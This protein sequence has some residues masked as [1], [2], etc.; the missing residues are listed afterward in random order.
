MITEVQSL[1]FLVFFS[2][3]YCVCVEMTHN[4]NRTA[5]WKEGFIGE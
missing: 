4:E 2:S 1:V 5:W 3:L